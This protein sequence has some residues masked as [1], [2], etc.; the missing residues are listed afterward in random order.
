[1]KKPSRKQQVLDY[2]RQHL[3]EWTHNQQLRSLTGLNDVPRTIRLLRQEGWQIE[4]R[5]DGYI[6]LASREK[7][8]ARGER[9]AVSG[10]IRYQ[11][12]SESG[13]RCQACGKTVEEDKVKLVV[14]HRI[15]VDWGG[16]NEI[17]NLQAL[18]EECNLGKQA[19]VADKS[20]QDMS[21]IMSKPTIAQRIEALFDK[22][23]NQEIPSELIRLVSKEAF[24]WQRALRS[25][26]EKTGKRITPVRGKNAYRYTK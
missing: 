7:G 9:K 23:P 24:D 25:I 20:S 5:G 4:V 18:C 8:E 2:L 3:K 22:Y 17:S 14:D 15:P 16:K 10:R 11:V 13:F 26:R 12:F 19:W 21:E 6:R 1:M